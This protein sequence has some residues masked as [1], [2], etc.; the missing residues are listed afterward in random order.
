MRRSLFSIG[1]VG[2]LAAG[3]LAAGCSATEPFELNF[4]SQDTFIRSETAEVFVV[5]VGDDLDACPRL[6]RDAALGALDPTAQTG[7]QTVCEFRANRVSLPDVAEG[8]SAYVAIVQDSGGMTLLTGCAVRNVYVD[9]APLVITLTPT[10]AYRDR[11]PVETP[12]ETC[13]VETKC[14]LGC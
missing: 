8:A 2:P 11:F 3:F 14:Q 5:P 1:M 10:D 7:Q 13:T 12:P 9:D 6:L 4:P